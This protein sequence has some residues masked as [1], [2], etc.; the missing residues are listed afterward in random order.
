MYD[1]NQHDAINLYLKEMSYTELLSA[2][3]EYKLACQIIEGDEKARHKMIESNLR[4]VIKIARHYKNNGLDLADLIEEG[5]IGLI[6]AVEKFDP[7]R[8]FRFSTYAT[9]WIRQTIERSLTNQARTIRLPVHIVREIN[10]YLRV[11]H[12]LSQSLGREATDEEIA[13]YLDKPIG[14][15]KQ[16]IKF[17][18][19]TKSTESFL[20]LENK[21]L[22]DN[23]P[24][25][26]NLDP[27]VMLQHDDISQYIEL[28]L[29]KLNEQERI[30]M[31]YRFGLHGHDDSTLAKVSEKVGLSRERVRQIQLSAIKHL[32]NFLKS[33]GITYNNLKI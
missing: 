28:L 25:E 13:K 33:N 21:S 18:E 10:T 19:R 23:I 26:R 31:E 15:I 32:R 2:D 22:L 29:S 9:W 17:N 4:L 8:R 27:M 7:Y 1:K 6:K 14:E 5:N 24:D 16:L 12:I 20:N 30:I 3:D 11:T